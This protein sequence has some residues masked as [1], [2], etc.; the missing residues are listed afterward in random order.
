[1]IDKVKN[2]IKKYE[3]IKK[4]EKIVVGVSGGP[5]SL[6]LLYILHDLGYNLVVCHINHG[7]RKSADGDE[8]FVKDVCQ[9]LKI[10]FYSKKINLKDKK[11]LNGLSTEEAGRKARYDFFEQVL[12]SEKAKKIATAHN[13]NDNA[14]TVLLNMFRGSGTSG[15]KGILPIAG[16]II[17][18]L[19]ECTRDEIEEYCKLNSLSPRIDETN[20][21]TIYTRNKVR[22]ELIPYLEENI[23]SNVVNNINRMSS[24]I[25]EEENFINNMVEES[26]QDILSESSNDEVVFSLKKYN[27]LDIVIRKRLVLKAIFNVLGNAKD[28][29]K[30]H[31]DD[32]VKMCENNVGG[33]YL[34]PN[35]HIKVSVV[36]K[37]IVFQKQWFN[38]R[39]HKWKDHLREYFH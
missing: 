13:A 5:D 35:K 33:K 11:E 18:P 16:H 14:E 32:I 8:K 21:K 24:I 23:N 22:L 2:T 39:R 31:V 34:T 29:E 37:K 19:I 12:K 4:G 28:I 10:P 38:I 9:K 17:R 25:S 1:M 30:V 3:L 26:Y 7:L 36:N 27:N 15:L 6:T 20:K